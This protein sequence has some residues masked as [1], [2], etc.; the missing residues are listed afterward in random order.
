MS[1]G[2]VQAT[3]AVVDADQPIYTRMSGNGGIPVL[4]LTA[5]GHGT[6]FEVHINSRCL[7]PVEQAAWLRKLA[8]AAEDLAGR[9]EQ[10]HGLTSDNSRYTCARCGAQFEFGVP[11]SAIDGRFLAS[12]TAYD[13]EVQFHESGQCVQVL[14]P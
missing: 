9:V 11:G 13:A 2:F 12:F 8:T 6:A 1:G 7:T 14:A 5:V 10:H 4:S 3:F